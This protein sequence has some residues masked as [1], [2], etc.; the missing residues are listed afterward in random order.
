MTFRV[1]DVTLLVTELLQSKKNDIADGIHMIESLVELLSSIRQD[2]DKYHVKWY[3]EAL[4][5][6][7]KLEIPELKPRT[8][9][10]QTF[11]ANHSSV[12]VSEFYKLSLTIPLIDHLS[13]ELSSRFSSG[14][15]VAYTGL[16]LVPSK[17][18]TLKNESKCLQDLVLPF[19][20]FYKEDMP[21]LALL[22]SEL[23]LWETYWSTS[24]TV[25]PNNVSTALKEI[26]FDGF[27]NIKVALRILATL[28]I[29]S[30][31][32]ERSF[33]GMRRLKTYNRTTM[34]EER[35]N[36]LALMNFHLDRIPDPQ[37]VITYFSAMKNR[38]LEFNL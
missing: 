25:I 16:Y 20:N 27:S 7:K 9:S 12:S 28:P 4:D 33:S 24:T 8:T 23:E 5:L 26:K 3:E 29:T 38:R 32:C 36:G 37:K 10:K 21:N 15:L 18:V 13:S 30:C 22:E 34:L 17:V 14:S 6:A 1:F 35:F 31:E 19:F 2:I 11:R